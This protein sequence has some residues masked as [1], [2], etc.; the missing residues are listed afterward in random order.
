M[1]LAPYEIDNYDSYVGSVVMVPSKYSDLNH[2]Y[3][4]VKVT[5]DFFYIKK[6]KFDTKLASTTY[7][8]CNKLTKKYEATISSD[9]DDE[10]TSC[11][12]IKKSSL[13][14]KYP[15]IICSVVTYEV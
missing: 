7:D 5:K 1:D 9:F 11:K 4:I 12:K 13:N 15:L 2:F 3:K 10:I 6:M 8:D 14:K